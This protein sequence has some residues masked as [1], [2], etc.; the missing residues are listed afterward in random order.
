MIDVKMCAFLFPYIFFL[1]LNTDLPKVNSW[2]NDVYSFRTVFFLLVSQRIILVLSYFF[3]CKSFNNDWHRFGEE[4]Y[5]LDF[6][7]PIFIP[8]KIPTTFVSSEKKKEMFIFGYEI[9][10]HKKCQFFP[11]NP[12]IFSTNSIWKITFTTY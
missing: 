8:I 2:R 4:N 3:Y 12:N 1:T 11:I 10:V 5:F 6:S 7:I 9:Y